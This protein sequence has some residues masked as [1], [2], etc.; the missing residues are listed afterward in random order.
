[1]SKR[2][3]GFGALVVAGVEISAIEC[4]GEVRK[5]WVP[6]MNQLSGFAL[7]A[8]GLLWGGAIFI[9]PELLPY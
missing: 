5:S 6:F 8:M 1:M 9:V 2:A 3:L 4:E 7:I